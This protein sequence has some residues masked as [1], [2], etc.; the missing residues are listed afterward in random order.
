MKPAQYYP[1]CVRHK[2]VVAPMLGW[3][4]AG[5]LLS[6][7]LNA[8]NILEYGSGGSTLWLAQ[9]CPDARILS[10]E[11]DRYWSDR[12]MAALR[13]MRLAGLGECKAVTAVLLESDQYADTQCIR[14]QAP[15]DLI[16]IDGAHE[17]RTPCLIAAHDLL[18][19][20]GVVILDNSEEPAYQ[21]GKAFLLA[22]SGMVLIEETED[23][24]WDPNRTRR[25]LWIAQKT[26]ASPA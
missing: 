4:H 3:N 23:D 19:P 5:K 17:Q 26:D 20:G 18:A 9:H 25:K 6:Y 8:R 13:H 21:E 10:I 1:P 24:T 7:A 2:L 22:Q 11:H 15:Y 14:N 12:V 16:F